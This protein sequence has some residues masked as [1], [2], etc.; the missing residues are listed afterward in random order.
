MITKKRTL[1]IILALVCVALIIYGV[2]QQGFFDQ[3]KS[4]KVEKKSSEQLPVAQKANEQEKVLKMDIP[5]PGEKKTENQERAIIG[6]VS[7]KGD[8]SFK[9]ASKDDS[10]VYIIK[11]NPQTK[12]QRISKQKDNPLARLDTVLFT[13]LKEGLQVTV[14]TH[15]KLYEDELKAEK[16]EFFA[17]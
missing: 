8:S 5:F 6:K 9:L 12:I 2:Q 4:N 3:N 1:T 7:E 16:I 10:L 13:D 15:D 14:Y 11:V 17:N